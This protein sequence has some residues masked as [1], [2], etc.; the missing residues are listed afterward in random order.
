MEF[1]I[2]LK[3][4]GMT[5]CI[6]IQFNGFVACFAMLLRNELYGK[7]YRGTFDSGL[8]NTTHAPVKRERVNRTYAHFQ[9][10]LKNLVVVLCLTDALFMKISCISG[11]ESYQWN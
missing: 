6:F 11:I 7:F 4:S 5:Y 2:T 8:E 10:Y 9:N 3:Y 1:G